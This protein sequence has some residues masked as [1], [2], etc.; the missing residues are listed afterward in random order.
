M[1]IEHRMLNE[2]RWGN[3]NSHSRYAIGFLKQI[4]LNMGN[5]ATSLFDVQRSTLI[6]YNNPAQHSRKY[7]IRNLQFQLV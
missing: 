6:S 4:N 5:G 2:K 3:N 1:N 7:T